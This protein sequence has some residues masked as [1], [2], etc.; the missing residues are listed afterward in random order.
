MHHSEG[1][2]TCLTCSTVLNT[3]ITKKLHKGKILYERL[4]NTDKEFITF[5]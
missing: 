1:T 3:F 4:R 2:G 5:A